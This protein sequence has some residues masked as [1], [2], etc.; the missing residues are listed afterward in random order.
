MEISTLPAGFH[1]LL[2]VPS[3]HSHCFIELIAFKTRSL[4]RLSF[5]VCLVFWNPIWFPLAAFV[6]KATLLQFW[7]RKLDPDLPT[8]M[9][10]Q[11]EARLCTIR[12]QTIKM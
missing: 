1:E 3:G 12:H 9:P 6:R 2:T 8:T 5:F 10:S 4:K 11:S 7:M